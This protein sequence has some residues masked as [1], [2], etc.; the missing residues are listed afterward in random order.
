MKLIKRTTLLYQA[1]SKYDELETKTGAS[2][3]QLN[4]KSLQAIALADK[5]D[6]TAASFETAQD[7]RGGQAS[8][9]LD[10]SLLPCLER[11]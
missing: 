4:P 2:Y 10:S 11:G 7:N 1:G 3:Q 5:G 8:H 9:K 6:Y